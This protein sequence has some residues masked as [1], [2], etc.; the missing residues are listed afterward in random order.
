MRGSERIARLRKVDAAWR[1]CAKRIAE[2]V[3]IYAAGTATA[4]W[5]ATT[6]ADRFAAPA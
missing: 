1:G 2:L 6:A 4:Q 5:R 3:E